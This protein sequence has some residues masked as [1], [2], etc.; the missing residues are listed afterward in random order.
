MPTCKP[1]TKTASDWR[2]GHLW[3]ISCH[4]F[5]WPALS[6]GA[7]PHRR[8]DP[9]L[10]MSMNYNSAGQLVSA[11]HFS[12]T[13]L[14]REGQTPS[15]AKQL[16]SARFC[17]LLLLKEHCQADHALCAC[18]SHVS[19]LPLECSNGSQFL[20]TSHS[21]AQLAVRD[22][23]YWQAQ[24]ETASHGEVVYVPVC[25]LLSSFC[26]GALV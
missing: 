2:H 10:S 22:L 19:P 13:S 16:L 18:R 21:P 8:R 5:E 20:R 1:R 23:N 15:T 24:M 12:N 7:Q 6:W 4:V 11:V 9:G 26:Q 14:S 3:I 17:P 25:V